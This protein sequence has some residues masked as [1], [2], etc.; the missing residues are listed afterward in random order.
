L[1]YS[2]HFSFHMKWWALE[3]YGPVGSNTDSGAKNKSPIKRYYYFVFSF[4]Y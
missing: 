3:K 2:L 4:Y 1:V